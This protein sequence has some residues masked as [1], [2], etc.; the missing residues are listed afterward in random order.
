ML[1]ILDPRPSINHPHYLLFDEYFPKSCCGR[2]H[3]HQRLVQRSNLIHRPTLGLSKQH[4]PSFDIV[5]TQFHSLLRS[6]QSLVAPF[7]WN[8]IKWCVKTIQRTGPTAGRKM[9]ANSKITISILIWSFRN[10]LMS[11]ALIFRVN[12]TKWN[13]VTLT[14]RPQ[15]YVTLVCHTRKHCETANPKSKHYLMTLYYWFRDCFKL[16]SISRL[17]SIQPTTQ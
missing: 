17:Y 4:R 9:L 12:I 5:W 10:I 8:K 1:T 3:S 2:K 16:N 13:S 6:H 15:G 11:A 7:L 14:S